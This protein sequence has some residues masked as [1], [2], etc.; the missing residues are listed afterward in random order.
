MQ[1]AALSHVLPGSLKLENLELSV[2]S[3]F[4]CGRL[5]DEMFRS[6]FKREL[7]RSGVGSLPPAFGTFGSAAVPQLRPRSLWAAH[8]PARSLGPGHLCPTRGSPTNNLHLKF[9]LALVKTFSELH[10]NL[11]FFLPSPL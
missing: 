3:V 10:R 2:K 4:L 1:D 5:G 8:S 7:V 11:G 9:S 6:P